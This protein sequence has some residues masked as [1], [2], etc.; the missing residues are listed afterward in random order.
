LPLPVTLFFDAGLSITAP[1]AQFPSVRTGWHLLMREER[2]YPV[3]ILDIG[4]DHQA[5]VKGLI[6]ERATGHSL[7]L[8]AYQRHTHS[9]AP[10]VAR[11]AITA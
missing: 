9:I 6:E 2:T 10:T 5:A 11:S 8:S 7:F 4:I 1:I 3:V